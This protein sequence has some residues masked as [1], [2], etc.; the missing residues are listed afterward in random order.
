M[1]YKLLDQLNEFFDAIDDA[2]D[3]FIDAVE[4]EPIRLSSDLYICGFKR[5]P[6]AFNVFEAHIKDI[7]TIRTQ[8]DNQIKYILASEADNEIY[9]P[10]NMFAD[11]TFS[12][13]LKN[14][15]EEFSKCETYH[16]MNVTYN[17]KDYSLKRELNIVYQ[18][19]RK[20]CKEALKMKKIYENVKVKFTPYKLNLDGTLEQ[21]EKE[22]TDFEIATAE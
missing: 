2:V 14:F 12:T 16:L 15:L 20:A 11:T 19:K 3:D 4:I 18:D 22:P 21:A 8:Q 13:I 6:T 9:M 10:C 17:E 1:D 7:K 5:I